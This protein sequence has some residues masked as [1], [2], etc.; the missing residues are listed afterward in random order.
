MAEGY[1][2]TKSAVSVPYADGRH[3]AHGAGEYIRES[4][5]SD[6]VRERLGNDPW[7]DNLFEKG[8]KPDKSE[9]DDDRMGG[10]AAK[11]AMEG[12][13]QLTRERL[14]LSAEERFGADTHDNGYRADRGRTLPTSGADL[15]ADEKFAKGNADT[16]EN[17][18]EEYAAQL[19]GSTTAR[20]REKASEAPRANDPGQ[21]VVEK[22]E[23]AKGKADK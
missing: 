17:V 11:L 4:D 3:V 8:G 13:E 9:E 21:H 19:D 23:K 6:H 5:L 12:V 7:L 14:A 1:V 15:P 18:P 20:A 22:G 10:D 2:K 16:S